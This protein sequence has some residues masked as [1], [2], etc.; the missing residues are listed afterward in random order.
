MFPEEAI[1]SLREAV[2]DPDA[3]RSYEMMSDSFMWSD[4]RLWETMARN[5]GQACRSLLGYRGSVIR[6]APDARPAE[7]VG[8]GVEVVPR[9]AR[10]TARAEQSDSGGGATPGA[11]AELREVLT[12]DA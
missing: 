3:D 12:R 5:G 8:A 1:E 7:G 2:Y 6:G 4:E 11:A 10:V 9:L